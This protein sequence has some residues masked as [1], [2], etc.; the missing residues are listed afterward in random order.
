MIG[1]LFIYERV[2]FAEFRDIIFIPIWYVFPL[3]IKQKPR[4][5][6]LV[7]HW[8]VATRKNSVHWKLA[9]RKNIVHWKVATGKILCTEN[10][11]PGK[12]IYWQ[13][14]LLGSQFSVHTIFPVASL[15]C[16]VSYQ[17]WRGKV[18]RIWIQNMSLNSSIWALSHIKSSPT[19]TGSL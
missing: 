17:I 12:E 1:L 4:I 15:Q 6:V 9:T 2:H 5:L 14:S 13:K 16:T 3:Q 18:P 19:M 10:R 7:L 11:L 8:K